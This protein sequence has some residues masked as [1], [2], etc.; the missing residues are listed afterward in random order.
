MEKRLYYGITWPAAVLT[1]LFGVWVLLY[2]PEYYLKA[3]WMHTKLALVVLLWCYH[4]ACGHYL[5]LFAH[6]K[7]YKSSLFFR[8]FNEIPTL[9][10]VGIVMLVVMKPW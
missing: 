5:K 10:L 6:N 8:L 4:L 9:L 2:N 3:A 1:T 7:N